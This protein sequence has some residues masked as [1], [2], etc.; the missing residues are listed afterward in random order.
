MMILHVRLAIT[1]V[2]CARIYLAEVLNPGLNGRI[3]P[4]DAVSAQRDAFLDSLV[5]NMTIPELGMKSE[6]IQSSS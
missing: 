4:R 3:Y 5:N 6:H 2:A 1:V